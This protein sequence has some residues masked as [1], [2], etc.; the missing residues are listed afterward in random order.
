MSVWIQGKAEYIRPDFVLAELS[1]E[2]LQLSD[3]YKV[4][5]SRQIYRLEDA[6][7]LHKK[8]YSVQQYL[9]RM[10]VKEGYSPE[11]MLLILRDRLTYI[12][13]RGSTLNNPHIPR[14]YVEKNCHCIE[15]SGN[16]AHKL[17][18]LVLSE[19]ALY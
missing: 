18:E 17:R 6:K 4:C 11:R 8:Q 3:L 2:G 1:A 19:L 10:D 13:S 12:A 15:L 5:G 14:G 9:D 16:P 7:R